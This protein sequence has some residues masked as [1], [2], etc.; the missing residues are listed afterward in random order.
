LGLRAQWCVGRDACHHRRPADDGTVVVLHFAA[1]AEELI[2]DSRS[3][4]W[5]ARPRRSA[6]G[7]SNAP[8]PLH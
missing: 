1:H 4:S 3:S 5:A 7:D 6:G 2:S 8:H